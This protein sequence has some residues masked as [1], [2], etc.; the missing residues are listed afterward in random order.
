MVTNLQFVFFSPVM[1]WK[2]SEL[3]S[4]FNTLVHIF[5]GN[6]VHCDLDARL[7]IQIETDSVFKQWDNYCYIQIE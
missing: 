1:R 5:R 2:S 6:K 7:Q 4:Q 3:S